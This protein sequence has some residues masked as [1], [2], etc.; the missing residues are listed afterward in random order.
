M[1]SMERVYKRK[2]KYNYLRA[3]G[4]G[5]SPVLNTDSVDED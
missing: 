2:Q 3:S 1:F 5:P 4:D